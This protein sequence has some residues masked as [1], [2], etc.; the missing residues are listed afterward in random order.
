MGANNGCE[1]SVYRGRSFPL[2]VSADTNRPG[3]F[4]FAVFSRHATAVDLCLYRPGRPERAEATVRLP[5]VDDG[6]WHVGVEGALE[7]MEYGYRVHGPYEPAHGHRF[8]PS[9]LLIDPYARALSG[10]SV[11]HSSMYGGD[12]DEPDWSDSAPFISKGVIIDTEFDWQG[13]CR[14]EIPMEETIIYEGHV[15][16]LTMRH[17]GVEEGVRGTY[18]GLGSDVMIE[19]LRRLGVTTVQLLPVHQ[20]LEDGFLLA[21]GLTNYWG[22]NTAAFFAPEAG[23]AR[24]G[25]SAGETVREFKEMVRRFHAAGLEVILDVVY[26]H[27]A[28]GNHEG[29]TVSFRGFDNVSYYRLS[30][31]DAA[32]YHDFTGTGNTLDTSGPPVLRLVMDSL[33]YWVEEMHVDG[34]RFDLAATLG[35]V[36]PEFSKEAALFQAIQQDPVLSRVKLIAEPWDIGDGGYQLGNFPDAWSELNGNFRDVVR[37]FWK[38]DHRMLPAFTSRISGSEDIFGHSGRRPQSSVNFV[39]SHDGFTMADLVSYNEKHNEA[40]GEENRDGDNHNS[41]WNCGVEGSTKD[42]A[43]DALRYQQRRNFFATLLLSH[44]VPFIC[45][46]DELGRSQGGNNNAY[47]QDNEI[48]WLDWDLDRSQER[49]LEYVRRLVQFRKDQTVCRRTGFFHGERLRGEQIKDVAWFDVKGR[50]M[51]DDQWHRDA[52]GEIAIVV[53]GSAAADAEDWRTDRRARSLLF[54]MNATARQRSFV[55]PGSKDV[56]WR[57]VLETVR[58]G[59]FSERERLVTG[60]GRHVV[61]KRSM[62]VLTLW[63]GTDAAAQVGVV[64]AGDGKRQK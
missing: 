60:G 62:S 38:G 46:G 26:N 24:A 18:A 29:P 40:N 36:N 43:I 61:A 39:T 49:F 30:K 9:K 27:T 8:N 10:K 22:Y 23:Y 44:G 34:F 33:R 2:G 55:V 35:R 32:R 21:K 57:D 11:W 45:A 42:D 19:Y 20:H 31:K 4:N 3:G 47:C 63:K 15:R 52:P 16:G 17:P 56:R 37:Q 14:P 48:S 50:P 6:V 53:S 54:L 59:G 13:D 51:G 1:I 58:V 25:A 64:A 5:N 7:G 12:D 28:E 41:S